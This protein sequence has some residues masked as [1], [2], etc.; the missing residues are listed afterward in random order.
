MTQPENFLAGVPQEPPAHL[1]STVDANPAAFY[2]GL[3]PEPVEGTQFSILVIDDVQASRDALVELLA[4][5][6]RV[7]PVDSAEAGIEHAIASPAPDLVL[8][9]ILSPGLNGY[10]LLRRLK[11]DHRT[12]ALPVIAISGPHRPENEERALRVGAADYVTQPLNPP[13]L[14]AR[15]AAQLRAARDR[16]Q[17]QDMTTADGLTGIANRRHFDHMLEAEARRATRAG[18]PLSVAMIDL[19]CLAAYNDF[20]GHGMG[21][22]ALCAVAD[23]L[24]GAMRRTGDLAGRYGGDEFALV[25]VDTAAIHARVWMESLCRAIGALAIPHEKSAAAATLTVS[26]GVATAPAGTPLDT[27]ALLALADQRL[28]QAK[29]DGRNRVVADP[30]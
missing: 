9:D 6:Y 27:A 25:M 13:V 18:Q 1:P 19:D 29:R 3:T 15:I 2:P 24:R 17:L 10:D 23:V 26:A 20:Y 14:R 7:T 4:P 8:L 12:A 22:Q 30:A 5:D 11:S 16:R 21:D 28:Q